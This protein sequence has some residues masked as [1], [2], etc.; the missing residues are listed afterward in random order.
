MSRASITPQSVIIELKYDITVGLFPIST[1]HL[2]QY[3][4]CWIDELDDCLPSL[5]RIHGDSLC[6]QGRVAMEWVIDKIKVEAQEL[7]SEAMKLSEEAMKLSTEAKK[8]FDTVSSEAK[9][10]FDHVLP[11]PGAT[12]N[13]TL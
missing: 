9:K 1:S 7:S 8:H 5:H 13:S 4:V 11:H 2:I 12:S 3:P 6:L 10:H